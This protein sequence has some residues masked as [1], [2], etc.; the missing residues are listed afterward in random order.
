[1][2][3][4][5]ASQTNIVF[6]LLCMGV[7][8]SAFAEPLPP[9]ELGE[10]GASGEVGEISRIDSLNSVL[11]GPFGSHS[12][13]FIEMGMGYGRV[14]RQFEEVLDSG[15]IG[16]GMSFGWRLG[17][18][19]LEVPLQVQA[20]QAGVLSSMSLLS[21]GL[22]SR[23]YLPL[24]DGGVRVLGGLGFYGSWL[25]TCEEGETN[26]DG[27]VCTREPGEVEAFGDYSGRTWETSVGMAVP[28]LSAWGTCSECGCE[29]P[30]CFTGGMEMLLSVEYRRFWYGLENDTLNRSMNGT[31]DVWMIS[32]VTEALIELD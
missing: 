29:N 3:R 24:F 7:A 6:L 22:R 9:E 2:K 18:F 14:G 30:N 10:P 26:D 11:P 28:L 23:V 1:M 4:L 25:T 15:G 19:S 27:H 17:Y 32:L 13:V 21:V 5:Q 31:V 8:G 20:I 16:I 12:A